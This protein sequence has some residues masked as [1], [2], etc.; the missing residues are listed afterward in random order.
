MPMSMYNNLIKCT[1]NQLLNA[2]KRNII[3]EFN[4]SIIG[5]EGKVNQLNNSASQY[6]M[7]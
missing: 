6:P 7:C 1:L 5:I 3:V 2:P 4:N